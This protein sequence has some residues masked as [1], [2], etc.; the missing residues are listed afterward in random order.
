VEN[1]PP[2][3]ISKVIL[4]NREDLDFYFVISSVGK[5]NERGK[6]DKDRRDEL[7]NPN[8]GLN[9][10]N[11]DVK[12]FLKWLYDPEVSEAFEDFIEETKDSEM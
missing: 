7:L 8:F 11:P 4:K 1:T 2:L 5:I 9:T 3:A 12:G 6:M 10:D